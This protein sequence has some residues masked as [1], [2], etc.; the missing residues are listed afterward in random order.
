[1]GEPDR[2]EL[3]GL[4]ALGLCGIL[5]EEGARAQPLEVDL[6]IVADLA[7]PGASSG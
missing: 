1:M 5:A 4:R 6:D 2:I 3:R 7:R